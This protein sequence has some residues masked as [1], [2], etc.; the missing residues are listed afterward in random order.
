MAGANIACPNCSVAKA[1]TAV[2][3][4]G[5]IWRQKTAKRCRRCPGPPRRNRCGARAPLLLAPGRAKLAI[6]ATPT[7][8]AA[9]TVPKPSRIITVSCSSREGMASRTSTEAHDGGFHASGQRPGEGA[10]GGTHHRGRWQRRSAPQT[11]NAPRRK[12]PASTGR[13]PAGRYPASSAPAAPVR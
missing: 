11:G 9:F 3:E 10:K 1:S 6:A 13:A 8:T 2:S 5:R 7:A 12:P 4:L